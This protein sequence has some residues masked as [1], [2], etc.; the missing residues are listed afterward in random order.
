MPEVVLIVECFQRAVLDADS[1]LRVIHMFGAV[2][3]GSQVNF[4][5][6]TL[7]CVQTSFFFLSFLWGG[8]HSLRIPA[9]RPASQ[10]A[11]PGMGL[12]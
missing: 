3:S 6:S 5:L 12:V 1:Q 9:L 8:I 10:C 4:C 11:A 7:I 2:I